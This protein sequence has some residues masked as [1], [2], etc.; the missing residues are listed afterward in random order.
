VSQNSKVPDPELIEKEVMVFEL[1]RQGLTFQKIAERLGY[2]DPSGAYVAYKRAYKRILVQAGSEVV[3]QELD[4]LDSLQVAIWDKAMGGD[5]KA[6]LAIL[7]I[8][9]RRAR[10]L[11][12]DKPMK[13]EVT[14]YDGGLIRDHARRIIEIVQ[15]HRA[16]EQPRGIEA[17]PTEGGV[18]DHDGEAG[19][20]PDGE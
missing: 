5:E 6:I 14:N 10:Y 9:E 17:E 2:A 4:R 18:G 19:A 3:H 1:R 16:I 15:Q 11:G 8:M 7:K 12:L 13:V 20:T